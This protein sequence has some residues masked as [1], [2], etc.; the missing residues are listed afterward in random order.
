MATDTSLT[1]STVATN[2]KKSTKSVTNIDP[3]ATDTELLT[4]ANA[5]NNVTTNTL[6]TVNKVT[7]K[8]LDGTSLDLNLTA[9]KGNDS[10]NA[11]TI[12]GNNITVD[13]TK[14][15]DTSDIDAMTYLSLKFKLNNVEIDIGQYI[16]EGS[17]DFYNDGYLM[18]SGMAIDNHTGL[19]ITFYKP[20]SATTGTASI[21]IPEGTANAL[22]YNAFK[23]NFT[24]T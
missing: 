13:S 8:E 5:L 16:V 7:K 14:I 2:G 20:S 15:A 9:S 1:M 3:T 24:F 6:E 23:V 19:N 11:I 10:S 17:G 4:F 22:D 12:S 21:T 18:T